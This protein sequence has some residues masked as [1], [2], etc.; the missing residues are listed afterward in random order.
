MEDIKYVVIEEHIFR[1]SSFVKYTFWDF[2]EIQ[3]ST[4]RKS[5]GIFCMECK[6][7]IEKT[8]RWRLVRNKTS[9]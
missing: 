5:I 6:S 2:Q 8:F 1:K 7:T 9:L 4:L 3:Y